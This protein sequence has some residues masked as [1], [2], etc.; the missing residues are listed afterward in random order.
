MALKQYEIAFNLAAK[1]SGTFTKSFKDAGQTVE[2]LQAHME[3]MNASFAE[4][5]GVV[6]ARKA[7]G[8]SAK[9]YAQA[10]ERVAELGRAISQTENPTKEMEQAFKK[11]K[12]ALDKSKISLYKNRDAMAALDKEYGTSQT[13]LSALVKRQK[14]FEDATKAA[15]KAQELQEKLQKRIDKL[16]SG[17]DKLGAVAGAVDKVGGV[18]AGA[19]SAGAGIGMAAGGAMLKA[20][21][22]FQASMAQI[23]A[24]TGATAEQMAQMEQSARAIYTSG[25]GESYDEVARAMATM[26][27][28][29]GFSGKELE[30]VTKSAML[31]GKTFDM[32][33]AETA[34]ASSALVKNFGIDGEKAFDLIAF[35]AQ[36]GAN[37]NGDL[38]DTF[39]EYAVQYQSL[40]FTAE[41]F[42]A[43]LVKGAEDGA[44]SIDKVGD[45]I[46][47]FNIR[48]KDG[49]K[50]SM[51]AFAELGLS[52]ETATQMF[53]AGGERA[54]AAFVEVVKRLKE[55][56]DPV[57]R[58]AA[59][60]ALFGTQFEDLEAK[61]LDGFLAIEGELPK[62]SGTMK[63]VASAMQATLGTQVTVVARQFTDLLLPASQEAATALR[64]QMP[65]ISASIASISPQVQALGQAFV[66]AIPT[67]TQ[68]ANTALTSVTTAAKY[69]LDN[70]DSI[71]SAAI[72]AAKAFI[73]FRIALGALQVATTVAKWI[74][75]AQKAFVTY[76]V[77]AVAAA[78]A[79]KTSAAV[80]GGLSIAVK[81]LGAALKFLTTNPIGLFLTGLVAAGVMLYKN[82]DEL[83]AM[84]ISVAQV[85]SN[86]W[87]SAMT[88]IQGFFANTFDS[89]A[90]IMK[91]PINTIIA[92]IN[93][94]VE[95]IN[96]MAFNVPDW[97]PAIG[98]QK[99]GVE[100]PKI[101]QLA[102]GGIATQP[103]L[104][105]IA[106]AGEAEAVIPLSQLST[107]LQPMPAAGGEGLGGG[108][109]INFAP[110]IHVQGEA[111]VEGVNQAMG[112]SLQKLEEMLARVQMNQR[113][114]SF[115]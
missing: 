49:S 28:T 55:I 63:S 113:R 79:S 8:E 34:R 7:V 24:S 25:M 94:I 85:I 16:S 39:N 69:I 59:G 26:R 114:K 90:S 107:M 82:W 61:A 13:S 62:M 115:A 51:E 40:G 87:S 22:D 83:K 18:A 102:E 52:G 73:G 9:A 54:Q 46:K 41:Q 81:A 36:N 66:D 97:V 4:I 84:A 57:K 88:S 67:L 10:R 77:S 93:S 1:K 31:L 100:L 78:V 44:F 56:D 105:T 103:T 48:A 47:E 64:D 30:D 89:L 29:G 20:G 70:F 53:A 43:H 17:Q 98:G 5:T 91:G 80:M 71:A 27:Q 21:A 112:L 96:G 111:G 50:S 45:A 38:L 76:R 32:D 33:V 19:A 86:A 104:A 109:T 68:W 110:V 65:S 23:Q 106:E 12:D 60:V 6:K 75:M 74:T 58:N 11:A 37:K 35:A 15:V 108:M 3:R 2:G 72:F 92:M 14:E 95:S 99:F 42:A 101:P